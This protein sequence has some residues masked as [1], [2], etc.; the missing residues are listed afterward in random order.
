MELIF[1]YEDG[2]LALTH[3]G[4]KGMKWGIRRYQPYSKGDSSKGRFIGNM[5]VASRRKV[6][7]LGRK[8]Q[9]AMDKA[10]DR[11]Y[12]KFRPA[13]AAYKENP[14]S[15]KLQ[16]K[17]ISEYKKSEKAAVKADIAMDKRDWSWRARNQ[18]IE[19]ITKQQV[20]NDVTLAAR[21][22]VFAV[23]TGAAIAAA[24]APALSI[25]VSAAVAGTIAG[26]GSVLA[27]KVLARGVNNAILA[28][29]QIDKLKTSMYESDR[30]QAA[31]MI[32]AKQNG[33]GSSYLYSYGRQAVKNSDQKRLEKSRKLQS[34]ANVAKAK[35]DVAKK[36][37]ASDRKVARLEKKYN[38]AN[39]AYKITRFNNYKGG[40]EKQR[41]KYGKKTNSELD[42]IARRNVLIR[43]MTLG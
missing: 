5:S 20:K 28:N 29:R 39:E 30:K 15:K 3:H 14:D 13:Q 6:D 25:P 21:Q 34:K 10:D 35:L 41:K 36:A 1:S 8:G 32:K 24:I 43:Q 4:V 26:S 2:S 16:R 38:N 18:P 33:Y 40:T 23:A 11:Y 42:R 7:S 9:R 12:D 19:K 27:R 22:T 17:Y 31:N 37:N